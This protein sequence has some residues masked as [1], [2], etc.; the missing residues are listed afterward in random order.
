MGSIIQW[1]F[2]FISITFIT[3]TTLSKAE[4]VVANDM[5]KNEYILKLKD[6]KLKPSIVSFFSSKGFGKK[7]VKDTIAGMMHINLDKSE[8]SRFKKEF[9]D[10]IEFIEPNYIYTLPENEVDASLFNGSSISKSQ[11]G[12]LPLPGV[13]AE[14]AWAFTKGKRSVVV[15]VIDTGVDYKHFALRKNMWKNPREKLD[16]KDT[17]GNGFIDDIY[18]Y[19]FANYDSDPMDD[20]SHGTHCA[21]IIA[22]KTP[23]LYGIAPN[24]SI[25]ALKFLDSRG[26][27]S[28]IGVIGAINYAVDN[29]ADVLSNS[30]GGD[31]RSYALEEAIQY[32][33]E[34]GILFVAAAGNENRN[35]DYRPVYPANYDV[36]N[37]VS[38]GAINRKGRRAYFSNY[39]KKSVDLFAPGENILSSIIGGQTKHYSGTSMATPFVSGAAALLISEYG[40]MHYSHIKRALIKSTHQLS[41]LKYYSLSGGTL[42]AYQLLKGM[43]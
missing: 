30:W 1:V 15:A 36:K 41:S 40:K 34:K 27:G 7:R 25:M 20:Q 32:A 29:G 6:A 37:I 35:T 10:E 9:A 33:E 21:G 43:E 2:L 18:G 23:G 22:A 19:D 11:W 8:L 38:V 3:F 12:L 17:D 39:G 42:D 31:Q 26:R 4:S 28:L 24:V 14:K 16:G 13:N 5:V